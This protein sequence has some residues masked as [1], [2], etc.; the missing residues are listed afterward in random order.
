MPESYSRSYELAFSLGDSDVHKDWEQA[1]WGKASH[2]E[3]K[4]V[5]GFYRL[6]QFNRAENAS[7]WVNNEKNT[8]TRPI[9]TP[10]PDHQE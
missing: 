10:D 4:I 3:T 9:L 1:S 8:L 7:H 5:Q 6:T 2:S